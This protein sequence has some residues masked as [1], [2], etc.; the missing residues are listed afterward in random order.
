[1]SRRLLPLLCVLSADAF[2]VPRQSAR[3]LGWRRERQLSAL[4]EA[5]E[6]LV[7]SGAG[8]WLE[9]QT[10]WLGAADLSATADDVAGAFFGAS[11]FPWLAMLYWLGHPKSGAHWAHA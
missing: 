5:L 9:A 6:P 3:A 10:M 1:M 4:T 11:L 7:S 8:V 2:V